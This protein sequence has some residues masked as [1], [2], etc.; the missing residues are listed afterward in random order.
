MNE[1]GDLVPL[2]LA[3]WQVIDSEWIERGKF[4][5]STNTILP[6]Q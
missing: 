4:S 6:T 1:N 2:D 3:I 5:L